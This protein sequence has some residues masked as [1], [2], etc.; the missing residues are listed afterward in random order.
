MMN[1]TQS[2]FPNP[3]HRR[4]QGEEGF[5]LVEL[6]VVMAI[7]TVVM[8]VTGQL[9]VGVHQSYE[10]QRRLLDAQHSARVTLD[11]LGRLIRMSGNDPRR[12]GIQAIDPD[13][14]ANNV[15]DSIQLQSD[16]NPP[17]GTLNDPYENI[18]FFTN[19]GMLMIREPGDP[20][21]GV[22]FA[23]DIQSL[24]FTYFD[25][26][27]TPIAD[28]VATPGAIAYVNIDLLIQLETTLVA[29]TAWT[30]SSAAAVRRNE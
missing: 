8:V 5:S 17:N 7:L 23:E 18:T 9:L 15:L 6:L 2:R 29:S 21:A 1:S 3:S 11:R 19:N 4:H 20:V 16:W 14:D 10:S 26:N 25:R 28:P 22:E 12:I 24:T 27:N 13:P 30:M